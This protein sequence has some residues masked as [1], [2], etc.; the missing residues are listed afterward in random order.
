MENV[1][2]NKCRIANSGLF[3]AALQ[4]PLIWGSISNQYKKE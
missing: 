4:I 1:L 3:K 2:K